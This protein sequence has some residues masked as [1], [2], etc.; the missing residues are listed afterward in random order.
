MGIGQPSVEG[1]NGEFHAK[2]NQQTSV[3]EKLE[4]EGKGLEMELGDIKGDPIAV[5][6]HSQR[7]HQNED[8][9]N[10]GVHQEFG[11]RVTPILPT[12]DAHQQID[13]HQLDFPHDEKQQQILGHKDANLGGIE[14]QH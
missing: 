12:P 1:E 9:G 11:S 6:G 7:R 5:E 8:G 13:R 3:E 4:S 10:G 2:G 14:H